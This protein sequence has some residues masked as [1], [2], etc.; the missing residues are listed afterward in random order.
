[1]QN[2]PSLTPEM[3]VPRL[4]E[5]LVEHGYITNE[6]LQASLQNQADRKK[7]GENILLGKV[8]VEEGYIDHY[9][10]DQAITEQILRLRNALQESN[11]QLEERVRLRT[12]ELQNALEELSRVSKAKT[13]FISNISHE[14]RTPL[15]HIKGYLPLMIETEL[16]PITEE[17]K[18]ALV[19]MLNASNRLEKLIDDLILFANMDRG[20]T[21]I[22]IK[23]VNV[24]DLCIDAL[25]QMQSKAKEKEI[26][27][28]VIYPDETTQMFADYQKISWVIRELL[29]NAI[30][31][32]DSGGRVV[33]GFIPERGLVR[34]FVRDTGIGIAHDRIQ[35]VFEPFHQLDGS[36][37]RKYKGVGLGLALVRQ[38][39]EAHE[40]SIEVDSLL[41][42][43]STFSFCLKAVN[44]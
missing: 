33:L 35:E 37:T 28:S 39:I 16:G 17:Q 19:A 3:L 15:T 21:S 9:R 7:K 14:L 41:G 38:I 43:G 10:L 36:S 12:K 27:L 8:L 29:E 44:A 18:S 34:I 4:G 30:K 6:Q 2:L 26:S 11:Q 31:F 23:T 25:S 32:T 22:L 5:Y 13:A 24:Q 42:K 1:M 20:V 40:S